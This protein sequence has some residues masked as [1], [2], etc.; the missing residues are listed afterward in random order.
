MLKLIKT[1]FLLII[2]TVQINAQENL[3][4]CNIR[5]GFC[6]NYPA[7]L[8][9]APQP[10]SGDGIR[11]YDKK[12][13]VIAVSGSNNTLGDTFE[14]EL[15]IQFKYIGHMTYSR[16]GNNWFAIAGIQEIKLIYIKEFISTGSI[17]RLYI[18]FPKD[19]KEKYDKIIDSISK[20]FI[21]GDLTR[22]H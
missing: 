1:T 9:S 13:F 11:I 10:A 2:L 16:R 18:E 8:I 17:N 19:Q 6:F 20:S 15:R 3:K 12:G 22:N 21:P 4:Y 7:F 5:Y 14:S